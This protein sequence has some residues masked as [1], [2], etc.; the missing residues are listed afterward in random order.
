MAEDSRQRA[1]R[2]IE[3]LASVLGQAKVLRDSKEVKQL[4][5]NA[6]AYLKDSK[7]YLDVGDV[8]TSLVSVAYAEGLLDAA[9]LLGYL[10]FEWPRAREDGDKK[11]VVAGT[12]DI[13]HPGH[14][15]LLRFAS[16]LGKVYVIVAR[17]DNALR[18]KG[19]RP[20]LDERSRL[21]MISSIKYVYEAVLGDEVDYL[22]PIERIRPDYIV[23]GPDQPFDE[24]RLADEVERR[25]GKRPL[26]L[27][28]REKVEFGNG[29]R[30][31][32]DILA[33][34][35][36]SEAEVARSPSSGP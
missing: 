15:E 35:C 30:G 32:R 23:L 5:E 25:T 34:A 24:E 11:V 2:Y 1:W 31:S 26:V 8:D 19:R 17:D 12:F 36:A 9:R 33:R 22:K 13:L 21:A 10:S 27:R 18:D 20:V 29:L 28:F 3:Q 16:T 14:I 7:Y 4:L 6:S